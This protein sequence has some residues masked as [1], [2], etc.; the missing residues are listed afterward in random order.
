MMDVAKMSPREIEV[1]GMEAIFRALGPGGL[2]R[3]LQQFEHGSGDY[4]T[5]RHETLPDDMEEVTAAIFAKQQP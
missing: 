4:S 3:F 2:V 5:E 1:A